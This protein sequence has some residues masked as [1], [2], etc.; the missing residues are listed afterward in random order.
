MQSYKKKIYSY[1]VGTRTQQ[2]IIQ[3]SVR[4]DVNLPAKCR[5]PTEHRHPTWYWLDQAAR[6]YPNIEET[7][8]FIAQQ[9]Q[10]T[11]E[12]TFSTSANPLNLQ[13]KQVQVY[14]IVREH[15]EATN[16]PPLRMIVSG[17]SGTGKSYLIHCLKLLL[18]DKLRVVAPTGNSHWQ[19]W[20]T[21]S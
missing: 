6:A 16:Q 1:P 2:P 8:S 5:P 20:S 4:V 12:H 18:Q 15:S 17:T 3:T 11:G 21:S 7:P 10:S 9:Q 19:E 14:S 13:G